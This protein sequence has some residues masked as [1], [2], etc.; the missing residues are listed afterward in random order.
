MLCKYAG[1]ENIQ[2]MCLIKSIL[3]G[4]ILETVPNL[5]KLNNQT[6]LLF[7]EILNLFPK[8][9]CENILWTVCV[10]LD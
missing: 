7:F 5:K 4:Y 2:L 9:G 1:M 3:T 8:Y 10:S 6:H